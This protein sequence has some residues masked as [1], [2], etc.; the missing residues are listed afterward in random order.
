MYSARRPAEAHRCATSSSSVDLPT[1][2]SPASSVTE[3]GTTPPPSTRSSSVT[4]VG[5][6]RADPGAIE[7]IGTAGRAGT[8][9][10]SP[11][12]GAAAAATGA[13]PPQLPPSGPRPTHFLPQLPP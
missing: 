5:C 13:M 10:R 1:P 7:L 4:P 8:A 6:G 11:F 12:D 3:P 9:G 2:G